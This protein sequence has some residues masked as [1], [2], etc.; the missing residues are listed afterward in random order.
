MTSDGAAIATLMRDAAVAFLDTLDPAQ[1][2]VA[3]YGFPADVERQLW[4]YTPTDHGGLTLGQMAAAQQQAAHRLLASGLSDAG[5]VTAATIIGLENVL[6]QLE[7]WT[8]SWGRA[9]GRDPE[10][11]YVRVFGDPTLDD[12]WGWRFGGHHV[13]VNYTIVNGEVG[14][15]TPS[16]LGADPASSPLLGPH[17]LRPLGGLEDLARELLQSLDPQQLSKAVISEVAPADLVTGNRTRIAP[18]DR[19]P[20]L[21]DVWRGRF[22]GELAGFVDQIQAGAESKLGLS[23]RH[24]DALSYSAA[25]KGLAAT[26][27]T[28][29]QQQKLRELLRSYVG[30]LPDQLA[31]REL[32]KFAGAQLASI[33]FAWAGPSTVG[34]PHYYR[35]QAERLL[36]EY[37]NTQRDTN[38]VHAVWRDPTNDFGIDSLAEHYRSH[39]H[40]HDHD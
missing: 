13:S 4:F 1:R 29:G 36:V 30:R 17:P 33:H 11:Y 9:R 8:A 2:E 27:L 16:F 10:L 34:E 25:P 19:P 15:S 37:D 39:P 32:E 22:D 23:G 20:P 26:D 31:D 18:G 28:N 5:Y 40:D 35:L 7:G 14:S 24:L 12:T 6:D 38:H 21:A 3:Q